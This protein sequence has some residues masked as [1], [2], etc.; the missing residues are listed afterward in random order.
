MRKLTAF[1]LSLFFASATIFAQKPDFS[2]PRT[3]IDKAVKNYDAA[4]KTPGTSGVQLIKS[5]LEISGATAAIDIDSLPRVLPRVDKAIEA[6]SD[7]TDKALLLTL[8]ACLINNIYSNDRWKY[9]QVKTPDSPI[10]ADITEWNGN[11]FRSAISST[12][13]DAFKLAVEAPSADISGYANVIKFDNLSKRIFPTVSSFVALKA[14]D[15]AGNEDSNSASVSIAKKMTELSRPHSD[16]YFY[17]IERLTSLT[18]K[19]SKRDLKKIYDDNSDH[20][21]AG[22]ILAKCLDYYYK[23][24]APAWTVPTLK[25]FIE[26]F[27]GFWDINSLKNILARLTQPSVSVNSISIAAPGVKFDVKLQYSYTTTVGYK[28]YK[29]NSSDFA[30]GN[31]N[32]ANSTEVKSFAAT[33]DPATANADTIVNVTLSQ[34]GY[35]AIMPIVNGKSSRLSVSFFRCIPYIPTI[36]RQNKTNSITVADFVTGAPVDGAS[37]TEIIDK[38]K[39]KLG[40]TDKNGCISFTPNTPPK[41][42][43]RYTW[44]KS[45]YDITYKNHTF[46]FFDRGQSLSDNGRSDDTHITIF[47]DRALYHPGDTI[48]WAAIAYLTSNN[49]DSSNSA[50]LVNTAVYV[51]LQNPNNQIVDSITAT[52][53]QFGRVYGS[54]IAPEDGLTGRCSISAKTDNSTYFTGHSSIEVSDFKLPTFKILKV[55]VQRDAPQKGEV[56]LSSKAMTYAGMPVAGAKVQAVIMEATR[57]R[58]FT[59][60]RQLGDLDTVTGSDGSFDLI[61]P[62]SITAKSDDNCFIAKITVTSLDGEAR[63]QSAPF[64]TGKP[65]AIFFEKS[66]PINTDSKIDSPFAA[67]DASGKEISISV[68]WWLTP[69]DGDD[70]LSN[71]V[72]SGECTT[73]KQDSIDLKGVK[74]GEWTMSVMPV[75]TTLADTEI[76][77]ATLTTYSLKDNSVPP[78]MAIFIPDYKVTADT[79]GKCRVTFGVSDSDTYVYQSF[80]SGDKSVSMKVDRFN[81]GFH[82][83]DLTLPEGERNGSLILFTIRNGVET[84]EGITITRDEK[85]ALAL[86]GSSIR[87][88]VSPGAP[89]RWAL[90]LSD[91]NANPCSGALIAT[92]YN[93]S[94]DAIT[95]YYMPRSFN[96]FY[97]MTYQSLSSGM[98]SWRYPVTISQDIKMFPETVLKLPEF[99]PAI[100][101]SHLRN[102]IFMARSQK[103]V[104]MGQLNDVIVV[105]DEMAVKEIAPALTGKAAGI[106]TNISYDSALEE[107]AVETEYDESALQMNSHSDDF[108]YRDSEVLQAF[109]MP[110]LTFNDNGEA[111]ICFTVPNANTTWSFNAF[112]WS[113]DLRAA[114]MMRELTASKPVMVQPNLPRFLRVGDSANV[115]ATVFNNSNDT[116]AV[117]SIIE[118]F[119]TSDD[120]VIST[121]TSVDTIAAGASALVS[122]TIDAPD[123]ASMIGYRVR[124]TLGSF[125][126]GEQSL[127]PIEPATSAVIESEA[128]YLNPGEENYQMNVPKGKNMQS[129]IDYTSNPAWNV[130]K[131]LPGLAVNDA[132]TSINAARQLFGAATASGMLRQYP[133]LAEVLKTWSENPEAGALT[134]RLSQ[135]DRLKAAV[136]AETPWVQAASSDTHRMSRL[137]MLF[138]KKATERSI[139][140]SIATLAKLQ[141]ADGGWAWGEWNDRSSLWA[142]NIVLQQLG[143]LNAIGY[144]PNGKGI[145]DMV[146]RAIAYYESQIDKDTSTDD[147][148]TFIASLF[149]GYKIGLRGTHVINAT[150][151]QIIGSWKSASTWD[152]AIYALILNSTGYPSVAKEILGSVR[153]FAVTSKDRGTS[154]PSVT[155]INQYAD[156]LYAFAAIEPSSPYIDGMRQWLVLRQQT[157]TDFASVDPTRLIAAFT[158]CGSAWLSSSESK[159]EITIDGTPI[160]ID[161]AEFATGHCVTNLPAN[162][163]GARLSFSRINTA[164]PAYG[165]VISRFNAASADVKARSCP[166]LSIEKRI[167]AFRDGRWQYVDNVKLGEQIRIVLTIKAK[168]DLEYVTVIDGRPAAFEPVDQLPGWVWDAGAGFYRENRDTATNLFINYLPKGTYHIAIDM[169]AS[170]AGRFTSGIATAQSQIAPSITAHSAG[171]SITCH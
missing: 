115:I 50:P 14:I 9:N 89:E 165:A 146:S 162:A 8:K 148:F 125:T 12:T 153:Q 72:A 30:K 145:E 99:S 60:S 135:N 57:W 69:A 110:A 13:A 45:S 79:S 88:N 147:A 128:F 142:T 56:I 83:I 2:H 149:P 4:I 22:Y 37:I 124:S 126:D 25:N 138:D 75:D 34:Q 91:A 93:S 62:D 63:Q 112:A 132:S 19:D 94:L 44:Y 163:A 167:T 119:D 47:T 92:M 123:D 111:F 65:Y 118:I 21:A 1:F 51:E 68:R 107:V 158:A 170:I 121:A 86:E 130:I 106:D 154:F 87:D 151:Q 171:S 23:D 109:W 5:L 82:S 100:G 134:S 98:P 36:I 122:I 80:A 84:S 73:G 164:G 116:A 157:V 144:L 10:P 6:C 7:A 76:D 61:V 169:T 11:Q 103:A 108:E 155:N 96:I 161:N 104:S 139:N 129:T 43:N 97:P 18:S 120:H 58:W 133:D 15:L 32:K 156:L 77:I 64:T 166:D 168:R 71:A 59:P 136:L 95:P 67:Y 28:I 140:A 3:T 35:Y 41:T 160:D 38:N 52:S 117:T 70:C 78:H 114:T 53:D 81:A 17:W 137:C 74:A 39:F 85:K 46:N 26:R 159:S 40:E 105:E 66:S 29:I 24:N 48:R 16:A 49:N 55:D 150:K 143:R 54:F 42:K 113:Q 20:E 33:T 102:Y 152:K 27:P 31:F 141:Q 101:F 131:E 90:K 127:I